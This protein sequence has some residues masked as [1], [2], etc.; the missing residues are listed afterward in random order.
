V[1]PASFVVEVLVERARDLF[2]GIHRGLVEQGLERAPRA[3]VVLTGGGARLEGLVDEAESIFG[4]RVRLGTPRGLAGLTEPVSGPEWA[5]ACGLV[6]LQGRR[7]DL[8][9][10][11]N[12]HRTGFFGWL[13][14]TF[15][16][17][18]NWEVDHDR[19]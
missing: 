10:V 14:N 19:V 6:R 8:T 18:F 2:I 13:R 1:H 9:F 17:I 4:H 16:E 11:T 15:G 12:K 7:E 3:G 5:V